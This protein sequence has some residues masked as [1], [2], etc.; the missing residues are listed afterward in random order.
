MFLGIPH[1]L[2]DAVNEFCFV[3]CVSGDEAELCKLAVHQPAFSEEDSAGQIPLHEAAVQ[4]N[5]HILEM[6]FKGQGRSDVMF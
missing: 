5:Q 2:C 3:L 1:V 6:T 4:S